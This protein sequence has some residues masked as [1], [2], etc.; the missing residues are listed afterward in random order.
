MTLYQSTLEVPQPVQRPLERKLTVSVPPEVVQGYF[1][2]HFSQ[3]QK[4]VELKGFRAGTA[5]ISLVKQLY[6]AEV[7]HSVYHEILDQVMKE[8]LEKHELRIAGDPRIEAPHHQTGK[9][10]HDH[11][12]SEN[13]EFRFEAFFEIFPKV[14]PKDYV[15]LVLHRPQEQVTESLLEEARMSLR[16]LKATWVPRSEERPSQLG[17]YVDFDYEGGLVTE[18]GTIH[19]LPSMK[20][21]QLLQIGQNEFLPEFE[22]QLVGL[23]SG[24][25]RT[26]RLVFPANYDPAF[27]GKEAEFSITLNGL[28]EKR[29]PDWTEDFA[30]TLGYAD[31]KALELRVRESLEAERKEL[32]RSRMIEQL[33]IQLI[34]K[35][36]FD[37][38][39]V[40]LENAK[41]NLV[42]HRLS[43]WKKRGLT[44]EWMRRLLQEQ[45]SLLEQ[46]AERQARLEYLLL[47]IGYQ[48]LDQLSLTQ[49]ELHH[50]LGFDGLDSGAL[51][52]HKVGYYRKH[53]EAVDVAKMGLVRAKALDFLLKKAVFIDSTESL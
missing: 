20:G 22:N 16:T 1:Q 44:E 29:L 32:A 43:E 46:D 12:V 33:S 24:Q 18:T 28:K 27:A 35:N 47:T 51:H 4:R 14:T 36:P 48:E 26:F 25:K 41:Q 7:S 17:D 2:R 53:P 37:L 39:Q 31:L 10:E 5:P 19:Y 40:W 34:E 8:V 49:A 11:H 21:H 23:M 42:N 13:Q 6:R 30:Q 45:A 38:P 50:A 9:G 15:G 52:A 3:L